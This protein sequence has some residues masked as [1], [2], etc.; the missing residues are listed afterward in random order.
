MSGILVVVVGQLNCRWSLIGA[1]YIASPVASLIGR[2]LA[3][4]TGARGP[5]FALTI[6]APIIAAREWIRW[7]RTASAR[8]PT[9]N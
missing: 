7:Q 6:G 5:V 4:E 2:P 9:G 1:G 3:G 8:T